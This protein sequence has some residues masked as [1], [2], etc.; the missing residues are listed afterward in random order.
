MTLA[1]TRRVSPRFAEC[2]VTYIPRQPIDLVRARAQH[3]GYVAAL[4]TVGCSVVQLPEE[5]EFP[6]SVFVED[7]AVIFP[8]FAILTRPGAKSRRGETASIATAL[9]PHLPLRSLVAPATLDGGDVLTIGRTVYVGLSSRTNHAAVE[10]LSTLLSRAG[11]GV[12]PVPLTGCL[13]LKSSVTALDDHSLLINPRW[14]DAGEFAEFELLEVD[15]SEESG[16]NCLAVRGTVLCSAAFPR[17]H[18]RLQERGYT[19]LLIDVSELAKAEGAVT[20]CSLIL[21][22]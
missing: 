2:E 15:S 16:A 22:G 18:A 5:P 10:Q 17:T 13:H 1:I 4:E 12:R 3:A 8:G 20:C 19:V 6:D 9:R 11:Y 7:A 21:E 14:V